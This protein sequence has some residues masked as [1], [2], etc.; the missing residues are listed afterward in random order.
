MHG[1]R[2]MGWDEIRAAYGR[3]VVNLRNEGRWAFLNTLFSISEAAL[4]CQVSCGGG[5]PSRGKGLGLG[6]HPCLIQSVVCRAAAARHGSSKRAPCA[7]PTS[8]P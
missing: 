1:T 4:Y 3:E 6:V 5:V 2:M 7:V 8:K